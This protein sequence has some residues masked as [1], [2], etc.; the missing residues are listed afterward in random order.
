MTYIHFANFFSEGN[1]PLVRMMVLDGLEMEKSVGTPNISDEWQKEVKTKLK[2]NIQERNYS[3]K[4]KGSLHT[5]GQMG[6]KGINKKAIIKNTSKEEK[7]K[8]NY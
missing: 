4:L 3:Q 8:E 6:Q 5:E 2:V 1:F 7:R